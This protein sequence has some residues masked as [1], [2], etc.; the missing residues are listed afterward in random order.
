MNFSSFVALKYF[1]AK[2]KT[3]FI[4]IITFVSIAGVAIGVTALLI[5]LSIF[6]GFESEVRS[7][8]IGNDAHIRFRKFWTEPI[9]NYKELEKELANI[10]HVSG[11]S[12]VIR[13]EAMLQGRRNHPVIIKGIDPK[14]AGEVTDIDKNIISGEL[15]LKKV[16]YEGREVPGIVLGK[17]LAMQTM[18]LDL[19]DPVYV[20]TMPSDASIFTQPK[21]TEFIVTGISEIGFYDYDKIMAYIS[22]ESAQELFD[23][24][25]NVLWIEIKLDDYRLASEISAKLEEIYAY[26][27]QTL[28]WY[29]QQKTLYNWLE[30]EKLLYFA[31]LSLIILVA[32]FNIISSLIMI[33]MEK[34]KEIGILKSMGATP[35]MIQ[36]IFLNEGLI[37]GFM[38]TGIGT[39]LGYILLFLQV[40]YEILHLP[41]DIFYISS[42][43]VD[44]QL[45]DFIL[46]SSAAVF[47]CFFAAL[48]PAYKAS[49]LNPVEAI[50]YE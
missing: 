1:R 47:L 26:P 34:T 4:S 15:N 33:V 7:R 23:L 30:L 27:Y 18:A 9:S 36:R 48:Y 41:Q 37:I 40:K 16:P 25:D 46:V 29:E 20:V 49:K 17:E 3:G 13:K 24:G 2:R 45:M 10:D 39:L 6:N 22:L 5:V 21:L 8:L 43:P 12:P 11:V 44:M 14:T 35:K 38:G 31:V 19:G 42:V 50:R 32:A 28:T